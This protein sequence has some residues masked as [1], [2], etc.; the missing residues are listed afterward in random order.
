MHPLLRFALWTCPRQFRREY[1]P[2]ITNDVQSRALNPWAAS[3]DLLYQGCLM[4]WEIVWRDLTL[5]VRELRRAPLFSAIAV[6]TIALGIGA[7]VAA[8]SMVHGMLLQPLP[9]HEPDRLAF[10]FSAFRGQSQPNLDYPDIRDIAARSRTFSALAAALPVSGTL[11]QMGTPRALSGWS[12]DE[13]YF[14]VLGAKAQ[15]GRLLGRR[16]LGTHDIVLSDAFWREKFHADAAILGRRLTIDGQADTVVGIAPPHLVNPAPGYLAKTDYWSAIDP[17]D[18]STRWRGYYAFFAVGRLARGVSAKAAQSDLSRIAAQLDAQY[19]A[20][21]AGR[22]LRLEP[23]TDAIVGPLRDLLLIVYAASLL[24]FLIAAANVANL[25]LARATARHHDLTVRAAVGATTGRIAMQLAA[26]TA[27]VAFAGAVAGVVLG[28]LALA[29]IDRAVVGSVFAMYN[30]MPPGWERVRIDIPILAY[31]VGLCAAF[32]LIVGTLPVFV[33]RRSLSAPLSSGGRSDVS[34]GARLRRTIVVAEI[35]LAFTLLVAAGLLLRSFLSLERTSPGYAE[36]NLY[37]VRVNAPPEDQYGRRA[38]AFVNRLRARLDALPGVL[39]SAEGVA[40]GL[41]SNSNTNYSLTQTAD[42]RTKAPSQ[43]VEWNA[44]TPRFF[45]LLRIP[46]LRGRSF[47]ERDG[48]KS[49]P[50]AIVSKS[51]AL[52][53][54][55]T[56][57][58]VGRHV[59]IGESSGSGFP[60]RTIVGVVGDVRHSLSSRPA[61]EVYAPFAQIAFLSEFVVRTRPGLGNVAQSVARAVSE[62]DP[63]LPPPQVVSFA[64][65]RGFD[66]APTQISALILGVLAAVALVLALAGIYGVL[67]YSVERRTHEFGIRMAIGARSRNV[68]VSVLREAL[69][70]VAIG[71]ALGIALTAL[72]SKALDPYLYE[73][74]AWDPASF[75]IAAVLLVACALLAGL[76][77][78]RR[79]TRIE[80]ATALRYE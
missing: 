24:V 14:D 74:S 22:G 11:T 32:T 8:G 21:E 9:F 69:L 2:S 72:I 56:L 36:A 68:V 38:A 63:L 39:G 26:E 3:L 41:G 29:W 12:V 19:P 76:I 57:D 73:T 23:A 40:V 1:G 70:A 61:A 80:P 20:F 43:F 25:L 78:A 42:V 64:S 58:V 79:A 15:I 46:L 16:D 5:G 62:A 37:A 52:R 4:R 65:L 35:V 51:F 54:F 67:S 60:L 75:V 71:I 53:E 18:G 34:G 7:N 10:V 30:M 17:Q 28:W 33:R 27:V 66:S 31:V 49:E 59:S 47:S 45:T 48:P 77:P 44:V 6:I 13:K 50:V 55:H